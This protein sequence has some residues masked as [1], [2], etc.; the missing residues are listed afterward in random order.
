MM[1]ALSLHIMTGHASSTVAA[2]GCSIQSTTHAAA[3]HAA[4][5]CAA[6]L[7]YVLL[8]L[9]ENSVHPYDVLECEPELVSGYYVDYGGVVFMLIYLSDG[10]SMYTVPHA[11]ECV[12]AMV[13]TTR[14]TQRMHTTPLLC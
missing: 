10:I 3:A 12:Y 8:A 4:C 9:A 6:L 2:A 1:L 5:Q 13:Y 11:T 7:C 14:C